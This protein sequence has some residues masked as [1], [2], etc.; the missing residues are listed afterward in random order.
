MKIVT[1][2]LLI[3]ELR[4]MAKQFDGMVKA[5]VDVDRE[6]MALDGELHRF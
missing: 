6:I 1:S 2:Q 4:Q 3:P 5:V